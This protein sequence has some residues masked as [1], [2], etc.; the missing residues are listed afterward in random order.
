MKSQILNKIIISILIISSLST[1]YSGD[2]INKEDL[3]KI[4]NPCLGYEDVDKSDYIC[5]I[6]LNLKSE[7]I[8]TP[9]SNFNP[10]KFISRAE[11]LGIILKSAQIPAIFYND[12]VFD[13]INEKDWWSPAVSTAK[14]LGYI[15][16]ENKK[17]NPDKSITRAEALQI[18]M[19]IKGVKLSFDKNQT[20]EDI[21]E[22][23][24][25]TPAVTTAKKL[26]YISQINDKFNPSSTISRHEAV[27]I[28]YNVFYK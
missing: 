8:I 14:K 13:D 22:K 19:N 18:I 24:W 21:N 5:N 11:L 7:G 6:I 12:Y 20:Y 4:E 27:I 28:I 25:W 26:G 17:F 15:S 3:K 16:R 10:D 1:T 23:D 2:N 9:D